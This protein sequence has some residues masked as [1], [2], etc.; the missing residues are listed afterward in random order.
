M[1]L[2]QLSGITAFIKVA[3][4]RSFTRA[5][6]ELGVAPPSLSE[7]IK[8]LEARLGVRLLNR[9]TR[10]VGLT[11]AGA[12]YL[13]RVGPAVEEV[14]AAGVAVRESGSRVA[15]ALRL[16]L[17]WMA[18]PLLIE[19]LMAPFL[20]TYP[21]VR[22]DVVYDDGFA[23]LAGGGFDAGVRIGELLEKD[24]IAVR[25]GDPLQTAVL[26]SP[27]Y[28]AARGRPKRL[29]D[30]ADHSCIAYRFGSTQA[31]S[32][33]EF[34][35]DGRMVSFA[36]D[37]R[38]SANSVMLAV[39]AAAQGLGLTCTTEKTAARYL[40]QG[41]LVRVLEPFCPAFEPLHIY[42]PSRRLVPP[43]LRAFIDFARKNLPVLA[44]GRRRRKR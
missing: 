21:D 26:A 29:S 28:L 31:V 20:E 16:N 33:W 40:E 3:E 5:A 17:P 36:P 41:A 1:R 10:S 35:E 18:G 43:K 9:T 39:E 7:A 15:G 12:T 8:T 25:L 23:D 19:P 44:P 37:P 30:L 42:Y 11:E 34:V 24:M 22:L 32:S 14:Q 6:A 13:A 27:S 2:D 4:T 38:L